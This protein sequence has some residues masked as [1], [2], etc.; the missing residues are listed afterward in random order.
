MRARISRKILD[1]DA[2]DHQEIK[3]LIEVGESAFDEIL[4]Y[5]ELI[6]KRNLEEAEDGST[7]RTV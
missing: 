1:A 3:F 6:E 5:N 4:A 7:G 2:A